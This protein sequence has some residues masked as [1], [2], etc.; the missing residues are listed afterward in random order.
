MTGRTQVT[1]GF[2]IIPESLLSEDAFAVIFFLL[3]AFKVGDVGIYTQIAASEIILNSPVFR[4][5]RN[6]CGRFL[7][8]PPVH[9]QERQ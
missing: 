4:V 1:I 2:R 7:C 6:R 8:I 9:F 5:R 3:A